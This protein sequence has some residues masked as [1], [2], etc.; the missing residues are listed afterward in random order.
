MHRPSEFRGA[1]SIDLTASRGIWHPLA[2]HPRPDRM[3]PEAEPGGVNPPT[4]LHPSVL[5]LRGARGIWHLLAVHPR[6]ATPRQPPYACRPEARLPG[7]GAKGRGRWVAGARPQ[8]EGQSSRT[9]GAALRRGFR[10]V[11]GAASMGRG[12]AAEAGRSEQSWQA[13]RH[14]ERLPW[15]G[16]ERAGLERRGFQR[17][18]EESL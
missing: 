14:W 18:A 9:K 15:G 6:P 16:G 10:G 3:L 13:S 11:E 4:Q 8:R 12:R 1:A 2:E 7:N 5:H 17:E